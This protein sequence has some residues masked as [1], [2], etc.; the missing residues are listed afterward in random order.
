MLRKIVLKNFISF[1]LFSSY[2]KHPNMVI[3]KQIPPV[4]Q[5]K[6]R[7]SHYTVMEMPFSFTFQRWYHSRP[8][9]KDKTAL[10]TNTTSDR[11][12]M[13]RLS[14]LCCVTKS[15]HILLDITFPLSA[16]RTSGLICAFLYCYRIDHLICRLSWF[17]DRT[18]SP[19][20][21][22]TASNMSENEKTTFARRRIKL[23]SL[24]NR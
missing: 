12:T 18:I 16:L 19:S 14:Q 9:M 1:Q 11:R 13:W 20:V 8:Q 6:R 21:L 7:F 5:L 22:L 4:L 3:L 17:V 23:N 2:G 24:N 10:L 15:Y